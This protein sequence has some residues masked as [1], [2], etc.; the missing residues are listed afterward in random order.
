MKNGARR[1]AI[2]AVIAAGAGY[3]AGI[4]T[5]PKSGKETRKDIEKTALKAKT[6]AERKLKEVYSELSILLDTAVV[7]AKKAKTGAQK[8]WVSGVASAQLAKEKARQMLSAVHE[9]GAD[10][11][12]LQKAIDD[13][14]KAI[15]HLKTFAEK[16]PAA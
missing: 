13:V 3:L 9:G 15:K 14:K 4:L 16:D 2:G 8:E 12:D 11:K 1:I 7:A 5:A 10:D 6:D